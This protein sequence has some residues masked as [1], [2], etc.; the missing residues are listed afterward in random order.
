M[1][2]IFQDKVKY[3]AK[4]P[5]TLLN[6]DHSYQKPLS[7]AHVKK[8]TKDFDPMGV[9]QIHVSRRQ[10]GTFWVFDGQ[11]RTEAHRQMNI[12]EIDSIVYEGLSLEEESRGYVYYNNTMKQSQLQRFKA[13]LLAD[14]PE[15]HR[16]NGIALSEGLGIDYN[17]T[18][19]TIRAVGALRD[20]YTK[21]G[22]E[23][24]KNTLHV[25]SESFGQNQ[26]AYQAYVVKGVHSF[27]K[28]YENNSKF[29]QKWL[30]NRYK[31]FGIA[32][33][34]QKT[35][36]FYSVSGGNKKDAIGLASIKIYN[37]GKRQDNKL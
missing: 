6:V 35:N 22:G 9:G 26:K 20:I 12:D 21:D 7:M 17:H 10:D 29:D 32:K 13:E 23:S 8:I 11:H 31:K 28:D 1:K 16:I 34:I 33:L 3:I 2:D 37:H 5:V 14:V 27:I 18:G 36:E 4:I 24:L 19:E 25:L 30:I 15:A